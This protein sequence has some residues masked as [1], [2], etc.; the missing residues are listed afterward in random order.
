MLDGFKA[1]VHTLTFDNGKEFAAH[2]QTALR[3]YFA[4]PCHS[5]ARGQNENVNGLLRQYFPQDNGVSDVTTQQ[6]LGAVHNSRKRHWASKV[7]T[8]CS[9]SYPAAMLDNWWGMNLL[10]EFTVFNIHRL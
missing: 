10:L 5:W 8:G 6:A 2:R 9:G 1:L 7:L 4:K 3:Y